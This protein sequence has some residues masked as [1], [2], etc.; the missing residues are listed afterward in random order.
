MCVRP[1]DSE[2][3]WRIRFERAVRCITGE[4]RGM[5][6]ARQSRL[7]QVWRWG[8]ARRGEHPPRRPDRRSVIRYPPMRRVPRHL[9]TLCSAAS[10]LLCVAV[11]VLWVRSDWQNDLLLLSGRNRSFATG[12]LQGRPLAIDIVVDD[13]G[14]NPIPPPTLPG[15]RRLSHP[16][17]PARHPISGRPACAP[18]YASAPSPSPVGLGSAHATE[19]CRCPTGPSRWPLGR[20]R[21]YS[22][23]Y[24]SARRGGYKRASA[25]IADTTS[26]PARSGARR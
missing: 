19:T 26:A 23:R 1:S 13:G 25:P 4:H 10:L 20:C 16:I 14:K 17:T 7:S 24:T 12:S 22:S 3:P 5:M 6:F 11:C 9:F 15:V 8:L 18:T 2:A 21:P